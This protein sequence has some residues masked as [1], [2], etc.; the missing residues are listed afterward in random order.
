M[1]LRKLVIMISMLML[2]TLTAARPIPSGI[3][4]PDESVGDC[5][6][7]G[8]YPN[9]GSTV[10]GV[11]GVTC[12]NT[13]PYIHV[14]VTVKDV[15]TGIESGAGICDANG[16]TGCQVASKTLTYISGHRYTTNVSA[17]FNSFN[18]FYVTDPPKP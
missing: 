11:G 7:Y 15:N 8:Y 12:T 18:L 17:Y 14:V 5:E 9:I 2:V 3:S 10:W 4:Q 1:S 6:A 16:G 13:H